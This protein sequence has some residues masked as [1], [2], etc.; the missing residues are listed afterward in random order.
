MISRRV[1][2]FGLVGLTAA[3]VHWVVVWLLVQHGKFAALWANPFG[4]FVAFWVSYFG[5]RHGSFAEKNHRHRIRET[6]PKFALV[7]SAGFVLN[8]FLFFLL[9]RWTPLPYTV[10]LILVIGIVAVGT[11]L[12]S[13]HWAF[14]RAE[15]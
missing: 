3:L 1:L 2:L 13:R 15:A 14:V 8:E 11:F 9:L 5:H 4:F 10:A 7:A 12:A 6:L